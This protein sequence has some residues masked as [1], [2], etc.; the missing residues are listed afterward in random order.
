[1]LFRKKIVSF[2]NIR[3]IP[4]RVRILNL[5]S[6][7]PESI[8]ISLKTYDMFHA[9]ESSNHSCIYSQTPTN[10]AP[11]LML[12]LAANKMFKKKAN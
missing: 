2:T 8:Y 11:S 12:R 7:V 6:L 9:F 10:A 1:M 3:G 4:K 5:K